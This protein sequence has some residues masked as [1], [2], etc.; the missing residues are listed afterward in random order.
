MEKSNKP[1]SM[2]ISKRLYAGD[3]SS[4]LPDG[5]GAHSPTLIS[6]RWEF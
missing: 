3:N 1:L 2:L 4:I 6:F 5:Q